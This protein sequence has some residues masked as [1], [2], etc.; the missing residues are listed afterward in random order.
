MRIRCY[1]YC[2]PCRWSSARTD[3]SS[4]PAARLAVG[5][6]WVVWTWSEVR[7]LA[8]VRQCKVKHQVLLDR[9]AKRG[10]EGVAERTNPGTFGA[11]ACSWACLLN[12]SL[13]TSNE[14]R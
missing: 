13:A 12:Q 2:R 10:A 11:P 9:P 7:A 5:T 14:G 6:I 8:F 1:R 4:S 3:I